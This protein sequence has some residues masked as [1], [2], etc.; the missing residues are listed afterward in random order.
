MLCRKCNV[1]MISGTSYEKVNV[2]I[3]VRRYN[4]CPK[5]QIRQ[6]KKEN[7]ILEII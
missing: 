3:V 4:V 5:C 7:N 1:K 6:F 2:K